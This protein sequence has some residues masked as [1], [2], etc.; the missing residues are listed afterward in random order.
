MNQDISNHV[1]TPK[2]IGVRD[3]LLQ[4]F[5]ERVLC[6]NV[7]FLVLLSGSLVGLSMG[8]VYKS[9]ASILLLPSREY[10]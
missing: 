9:Q 8:T 10:V 6:R 5:R 1:F 4:L 2:P 3:V 7:F